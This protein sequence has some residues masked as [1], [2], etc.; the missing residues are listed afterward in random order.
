MSI[1][2]IVPIALG[3]FAGWIVNYLS[4]VLP[5][6]RRFSQPTCPHCQSP[7]S[8]K[9]Y[10]LFQPCPNGHARGIRPWIVQAAMIAA[11]L[12]AW[13]QPPSKPGFILGFLLIVY[14]G[15]VVVI[16]LEHRLILHPTSVAGA[17]LALVVGVISHGWLPSL[18]GGL[19]GF[20]IMFAFYLLGVWFTRVRAKRLAARGIQADDEEA[21]GAG[22]V[23]LVTVLGFL[24]GWPL[25]W[26]CILISILLGGIVS[27]FTIIA[28]F[29]TRGYEKNA[30]M[31]FIPYG[32]YFIVSAYLITF[33]PR[34]VAAFVPG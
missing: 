23:I 29:I 12:Y 15:V 34:F 3:W 27:L 10:L 20:L 33:F 26:L 5:V 7:Y 17:L 8:L 14:F 18:Q 2:L 22:D 31:L 1:L 25:V 24:V 32:P 16:D 11:S 4:D 19:A 28:L 21:L 13:I 6:T 9:G 30:L